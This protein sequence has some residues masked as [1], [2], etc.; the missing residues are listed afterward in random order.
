VEKA[1]SA[2]HRLHSDRE[3]D[4]K[5]KKLALEEARFALH[6]LAQELHE[7]AHDDDHDHDHEDGHEHEHGESEEHE[8]HQ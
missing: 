2:L 3:I 1:A 5:R 4:H 7:H 6:K 8:D